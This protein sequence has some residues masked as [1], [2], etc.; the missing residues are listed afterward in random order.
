MMDAKKPLKA[1]KPLTS[2]FLAGLIFTIIG[3]VLLIIFLGG[4]ITLSGIS[5]IF[6]PFIG[7]IMIVI[8]LQ[9]VLMAGKIRKD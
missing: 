3:F 2:I 4:F 7:V 1:S 8:G 6:I 5:G 9:L